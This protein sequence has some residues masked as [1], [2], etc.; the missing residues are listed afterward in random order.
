[1]S[2]RQKPLA[3]QFYFTI[4]RRVEVERW[5]RRSHKQYK[6]SDHLVWNIIKYIWQDFPEV[7]I[8]KMIKATISI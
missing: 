7:P 1:M 4:L 2:R 8:P 3:G 6:N 5:R